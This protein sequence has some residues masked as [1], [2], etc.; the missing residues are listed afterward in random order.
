MKKIHRGKKYDTDTAKVVGARTFESYRDSKDHE[1]I[2]KIYQ[3][4]N[5]EFFLYTAGLLD[6]QEIDTRIEPIHE[7]TAKSHL[8]DMLTVEEYEAI[9]GYVEE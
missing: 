7:N 9:F 1:Y 5:G 3:K 6:G 4:N 8:E 2:Y